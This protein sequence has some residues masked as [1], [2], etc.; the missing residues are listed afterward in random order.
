MTG[1]LELVPTAQASAQRAAALTN[2]LLA[3]S[4]HQTLDPRP[5]DMNRLVAGMEDLIRRTAGP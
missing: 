4:R 1:G 2:R 5:T 3:F